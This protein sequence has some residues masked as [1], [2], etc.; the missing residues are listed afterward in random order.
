VTVAKARKEEAS[1]L[2]SVPIAKD[3]ERIRV[4]G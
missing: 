2:E 3:L 1:A 4:I